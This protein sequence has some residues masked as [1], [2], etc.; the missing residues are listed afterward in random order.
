VAIALIDE[1]KT[2]DPESWNLSGVRAPAFVAG[3]ELADLA[4]RDDRVVVLTA[5]LAYSNRTSEFAERHP[6]RF[7]NVGIAEQNMVS[8]AA[9]IATCGFVP[10][11][12]TFASFV[13]LLCVEQI[14]TDIAYPSLP[15]RILAHHA[16]MA[17]G[18]YGTSH[19]AL[20]DIGIMRSIAGLAVVSATDEH[21]LRSILRF[22]VGYPGPVYIRMG[23]GR[24]PEVYTT[25]PRFELGCSFRVREGKDV[26]VL[27]TGAEV[28]PAV[29]AADL[30]SDEGIGVRVVDMVSLAPLD[31]NA[32][33]DAARD[34]GAVVT[35][36]EH[37]VTGGLGSA[38]ADVLASEGI[39]VPFT[40]HGVQDLYPLV[41]P[42]AALYAHYRLDG[43][44]LGE[45][46]KER[47]ARGFE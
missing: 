7:V 28:A 38:A 14:R 13:G 23:R 3:M 45:I 17:L 21:M 6:E 16:G 46:I 19:H 15:V 24:D 4:D 8:M 40:K 20:E 36:E 32:V 22:S 18:F 27:A 37:N 34:C 1:F 26:A 41:G 5:D 25:P 43:P 44:G 30:L 35:V 29:Q 12:A 31:R 11:A 10:Y 33:V 47:L 42:P 9:G 39:A 2:R